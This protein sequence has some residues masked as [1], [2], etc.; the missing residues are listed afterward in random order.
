[1]LYILTRVPGGDDFVRGDDINWKWNKRIKSLEFLLCLTLCSFHHWAQSFPSNVIKK[2]F[3]RKR[4]YSVVVIGLGNDAGYPGSN[5][6]DGCMYKSICRSMNCIQYMNYCIFL[7]M[8]V[9]IFLVRSCLFFCYIQ[10]QGPESF[11]CPATL[12]TNEGLV[13]SANQRSVWQGGIVMAGEFPCRI[14]LSHAKCDGLEMY[15]S[16]LHWIGKST[17]QWWNCA[18]LLSPGPSV[19]WHFSE[20][21]MTRS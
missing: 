9:W 20:R 8:L 1:M 16:S 7:Y 6:V 15:P 4:Q 14:W 12:L 19:Y 10:R 17:L 5:P 3:K 18:W 13:Q 21:Y 2:V 11:F